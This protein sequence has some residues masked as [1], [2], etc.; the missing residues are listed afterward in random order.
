MTNSCAE[1]SG[2]FVNYIGWTRLEL[3]DLDRIVH[4]GAKISGIIGIN[5]VLSGLIPI[6]Y[7]MGTE[8]GIFLRKIDVEGVGRGIIF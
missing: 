2:K 4:S 7:K 3:R 1:E 5:R 8:A 6:K